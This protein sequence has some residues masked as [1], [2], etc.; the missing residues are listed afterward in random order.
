MIGKN[1][2][3]GNNVTITG[4]HIMNNVVIKDNCKV[5]NSFID[6]HC[7][8]EENSVIENGTIIASNVVVDAGSQLKG[9]LLES[10]EVDKGMYYKIL[11]PA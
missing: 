8:I 1:C 11:Q 9:S 10:S 5:I 7:T 4:S 6:E 2:V 3:I